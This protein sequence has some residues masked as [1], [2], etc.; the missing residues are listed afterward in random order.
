MRGAS[1]ADGQQHDIAQHRVGVL[2]PGHNERLDAS[3]GEELDGSV[4]ALKATDAV[5][6][7]VADQLGHR[8][9]EGENGQA[10]GAALPGVVQDEVDD[11]SNFGG[12]PF[13]GAVVAGQHCR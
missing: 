1:I 6:H 11:P 5:A 10:F 8:R 9:C 13:D 3:S 7:A 2:D 12:R 4:V